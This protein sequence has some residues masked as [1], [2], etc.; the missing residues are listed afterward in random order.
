MLTIAL[1]LITEAL[2]A[3][4]AAPIPALPPVV[5]SRPVIARSPWSEPAPAVRVWLGGSTTLRRGETPDLYFRADDDAYVAVVRIDTDGR[6]ELIFPAA[7]DR[8][9]FARAGR[10]YRVQGYGRGAFRVDDEPG[11]GYVFAL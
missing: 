2:A 10:T 9:H 1:A 4:A 11:M 7:P 5:V 8:A 3:S 6:E